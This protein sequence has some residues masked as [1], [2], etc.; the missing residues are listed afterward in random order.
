MAR[1]ITRDRWAARR[2]LSNWRVQLDLLF[3]GSPPPMTLQ[4]WQGWLAQLPGPVEVPTLSF[5][6]PGSWS[7]PRAEPFNVSVREL[8]PE[9]SQL[10]PL[11]AIALA[12][13]LG[14]WWRWKHPVQ[15]GSPP[16]STA[17]SGPAR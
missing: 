2:A 13:L 7:Q 17:P 3:E 10:A 8:P 14:F 15:W 12:L 5:A 1:Q 4:V 16:T 11:L 6:R 9:R